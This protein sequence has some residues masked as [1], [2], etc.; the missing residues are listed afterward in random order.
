MLNT[1]ILKINNL[2]LTNAS[3]SNVWATNTNS[4]KPLQLLLHDIGNLVIQELNKNEKCSSNNILW[5]SFDFP[6]DTLL[7]EQTLTRLANL[8]SSKRKKITHLVL[9]VVIEDQWSCDIIYLTHKK[10][11]W[12]LLVVC[13]DVVCKTLQV[14]TL[15]FQRVCLCE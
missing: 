5:Q 12:K 1:S 13:V 4:S 7:L 2:F 15:R 11:R 8:V 14:E 6:T 3:Q 10:G 9:L